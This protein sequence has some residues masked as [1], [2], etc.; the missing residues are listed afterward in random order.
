MKKVIVLL[1]LNFL[2][3]TSCQF[4]SGTQQGNEDTLKTLN[5]P[6]L[7]Y[8]GNVVQWEKVDGALIYL[9]YINDTLITEMTKCSYDISKF[10]SGTFEIKVVAKG[11]ENEIS[12]P[13][14]MVLTI[15]APEEVLNNVGVVMI[16]DTHGAILDDGTPGIAKISTILNQYSEE[17]GD[18]LTVANGDIFQGSYAS[19]ILKG[20]PLIDAMNAMDFDCFVVGNHEFDWGFDKIEVYKDGNLENGEAEFPFLGANIYDRAT[21]EMVDWLEPYTI[22]EKNGLKVGIIGIIG[23][24]LESSILS[25]YIAEYEFV[26]PLEIIKEHAKTLRVEEEC[27][28]VI[29][30]NH[31]YDED[32]NYSISQLN[33]DYSIDLILCGHTHSNKEDYYTRPDGKTIL[34]VQNRDKNQTASFVNLIVDDYQNYIGLEFERLYPEDFIEDKQVLDVLN[35]YSDIFAE[36]DKI[37]GTSSN[38]LSKK[39]L[40][41]YATA[42][43]VEEFDCDISIINTAGV[44]STIDSGEIKVADVFNAFPF[45]NE[46]YLVTLLGSKVKSLY[47]QNSNY[48]YFNQGFNISAINNNQY[49]E[50]AVIDYVFT[51]PYYNEF[52]NVSYIDNDVILRDLLIDYIDNKH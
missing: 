31:D 38:Y 16:N 34:A 10:G 25:T 19:N 12:E 13:G 51:S 46:V 5:T 26:Y 8:E 39:T 29:V 7:S 3:L 24:T 1:L 47:Q 36:G 35:V 27:D 37:L 49:Y 22:V 15:E 18:L 48:L 11:Y 14:T 52:K 32:L 43:M 21:N 20:R 40:G 4:P 9:F 44:R 45:D 23:Y 28:L 41:Y 30:S 50:I 6:V 33:G 17:Y 2:F 42:A